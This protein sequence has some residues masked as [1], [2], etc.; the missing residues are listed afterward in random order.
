MFADFDMLAA[1]L[2]HEIKNPLA[3]VRANLDYIELCDTEKRY[4]N[5]YTVMKRQLE[6]TDS[7]L[8]DFVG[9]VS[10]VGIEDSNTDICAVI[11]GVAA[12]Y[13]SLPI[14]ADSFN[15]EEADALG[16]F[17]SGGLAVIKSNRQT[18]VDLEITLSL[19]QKLIVRGSRKLLRI[20]FSNAIKNAAE[21]GARCVYIYADEKDGRARITVTD[22]GPGLSEEALVHVGESGGYTTKKYGNGLGILISRKIIAGYGGVYS[23]GNAKNGGCEVIIE[24]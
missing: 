11:R 4:A 2:A 5:S 13:T 24:I 8:Q 23:I 6:R 16:G 12:D 10:G 9:L 18:K 17:P 7:L 21:A 19:P 15:L 1:T 3:L 20:V 14:F 22:D